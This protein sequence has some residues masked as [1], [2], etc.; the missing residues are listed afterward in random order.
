M[1][2][3]AHPHTEFLIVGRKAVL[4]TFTIGHPVTLYLLI[5]DLQLFS[6][7]RVLSSN[8]LLSADPGDS[9]PPPVPLPPG[10]SPS[11][12][13]R[14]HLAADHQDHT[15][16][17]GGRMRDKDGEV[18]M[19]IANCSPHQYQLVKEYSG[20]TG[21]LPIGGWSAWLP[22]VFES[23]LCRDWGFHLLVAGISL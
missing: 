2:R 22:L 5:L 8:C 6:C 23:L 14:G 18:R 10:C 11:P 13:P 4:R 17:G 21:T 1:L 3:Q 12:S 7:P 19:G 15:A 20:P 9:S 16:G